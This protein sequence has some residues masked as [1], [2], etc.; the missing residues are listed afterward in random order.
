LLPLDRIKYAEERQVTAK[1][2]ETGLSVTIKD[3]GRTVWDMQQEAHVKL[4]R[5]VNEM[6]AASG[7][8]ARG[9]EA[10]GTEV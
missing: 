10:S 4:S 9:T 6:E 2:R 7:T 1:D 5:L 8:E 3:S